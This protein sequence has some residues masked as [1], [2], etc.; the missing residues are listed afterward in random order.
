MG[1]AVLFRLCL[2]LALVF[3]AVIPLGAFVS[4]RFAKALGQISSADAIAA[5]ETAQQAQESLT[6]F[7]EVFSFS[8]QQVAQWALP[9]S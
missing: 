7:Q 6:N 2:P 8:N 4:S 1:L 9:S 3:A 5:A